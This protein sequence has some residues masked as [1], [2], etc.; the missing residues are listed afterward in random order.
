ML[1]VAKLYLTTNIVK[2]TTYFPSNFVKKFVPGSARGGGGGMVT[3]KGGTCII[4]DDCKFSVWYI[5]VY[6][7][8]VYSLVYLCLS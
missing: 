8:F 4:D 1:N 2:K 5:E 6:A 3:C 7:Y